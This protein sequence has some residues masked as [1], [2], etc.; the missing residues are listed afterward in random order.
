[1]AVL[2]FDIGKGKASVPGCAECPQGRLFSW[3]D[4]NRRGGFWQG[5]SRRGSDYEDD[6][7]ED[8]WGSLIERELEGQSSD[9]DL[10]PGFHG[11][12]IG[13]GGVGGG[14]GE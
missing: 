9:G 4:E 7:E 3:R 2:A 13:G 12:R 1:M 6:D 11:G 5:L 8:L 14:D 10:H